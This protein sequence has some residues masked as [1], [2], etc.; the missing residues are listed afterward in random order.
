MVKMEKM[1][2]LVLMART[3]KMV[4]FNQLV[5]PTSLA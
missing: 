2:I 5:K 4:V 3:A 1:V